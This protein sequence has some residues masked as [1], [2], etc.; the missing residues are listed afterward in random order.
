MYNYLIIFYE[1]GNCF[2]Q[3]FVADNVQEALNCALKEN[4]IER[5]FMILSISEN[6]LV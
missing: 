1:S 5:I 3:T 2:Y 6:K 4:D